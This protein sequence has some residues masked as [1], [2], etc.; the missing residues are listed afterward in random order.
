MYNGSTFAELFADFWWL[1][2]PLAFFLVLWWDSWLKYRRHK[3]TIDLL[4]SYA[5]S[6]KEPPANLLA[7]LEK[8]AASDGLDAAIEDSVHG[9]PKNDGSAPFLVVLMFGLAGVFAYVTYSGML[10]LGDGGYFV[11]MIL[12]VVGFAFLVSALFKPRG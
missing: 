2:F 11:A 7:T 6:G 4:K 10:D 5:A 3:S 8:T 12:G 1:I 9:E